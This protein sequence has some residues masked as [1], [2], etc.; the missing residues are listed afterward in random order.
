MGMLHLFE[1]PHAR[2][3]LRSLLRLTVSGGNLFV[4]S[5]VAQRA[6]GRCYLALLHRAGEVATPRS[7][8]HLAEMLRVEFGEAVECE[9]EGSM[10]YAAAQA[11]KEVVAGPARAAE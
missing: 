6:I 3:F 7:C 2:D 10:A 9:C 4:T 5:L 8:E 11:I 1:D